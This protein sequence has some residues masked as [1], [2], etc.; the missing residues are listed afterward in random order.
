MSLT[1]YLRLQ[2]FRRHLP[3]WIGT[4]LLSAFF[5]AVAEHLSPFQRQFKLSDPTLQHPFA[6][7]ERV[8]G[9]RC[10]LI[11]SI[12]PPFIMAVVTL[13]KH[14]QRPDHG[15]HLWAVSVLGVFVAVTVAGTVIDI[16]KVWIGRPRPDFLARCS[17]TVG[18]PVDEYVTS[19]VCTAPF[20]AK[21]LID[22][23]KSTPSGHLALSF[24]AFGY[25]T[26]WLTAQ[27]GLAR[28]ECPVHWY[29]AAGLPLIFA[30]YIALSRTQDY[31]HHFVDIIVG[32]FIGSVIAKGAYRK[33]F[34]AVVDGADPLDSIDDTETQLPL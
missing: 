8:S 28:A 34:P 6:V 22:G 18:T 5:L 20:G 13:L 26:A 19:A 15:F 29:F 4:I 2:R 23:M 21:V 30:A 25:L 12:V 31:R 33:Y 16:L 32:G 1:K 3:D 11:V 7:T 27:F 9:P 10:L 24:A 14:R 17:A